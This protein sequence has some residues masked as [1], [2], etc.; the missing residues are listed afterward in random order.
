MARKRKKVAIKQQK[1]KGPLPWPHLAGNARARRRKANA[2]KKVPRGLKSKSQNKYIKV[3][4]REA[5]KKIYVTRRVSQRPPVGVINTEKTF[6]ESQKK[7]Q[8]V[9][10]DM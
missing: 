1:G 9:A 3:P 6:Q 10:W 8:Q 7:P 5:F 4:E 2:L